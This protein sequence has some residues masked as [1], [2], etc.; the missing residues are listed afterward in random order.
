[1]IVCY[2]SHDIPQ[3]W[4]H[5]RPYIQKALDCGSNWSIGRAYEALT[6]AKAQCWTWQDP[7]LRAVLVTSLEG[8]HCFLVALGGE[9][10]AVWFGALEEVEK[11]ARDNG[12]KSLKVIGRR[13]WSR[14]G[15][16]VVGRDGD[17][18]VME[19]DLWQADQAK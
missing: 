14:M 17:H 13:G 15:F 11:F 9:G 18:Y 12:C 4:P 3:I 16:D 7:D 19:R 1:M 6:S 10:M 2:P 5:I 8:S